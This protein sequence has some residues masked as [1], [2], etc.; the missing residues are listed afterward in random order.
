MTATNGV[1][2]IIIAYQPITA[3]ASILASAATKRV[4]AWCQRLKPPAVDQRTGRSG[5]GDGDFGDG[6]GVEV[7]NPA[8]QHRA[9]DRKSQARRR[10]RREVHEEGSGG[11]AIEMT[12]AKASARTNVGVPNK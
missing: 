4:R 8:F 12:E 10:E 9:A 1:M 5:V 6:V 7:I 3:T 11:V 2:V